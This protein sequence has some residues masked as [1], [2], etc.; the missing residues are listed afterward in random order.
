MNIY[1]IAQPQIR[2]TL[3]VIAWHHNTGSRK[4]LQEGLEKKEV[5]DICNIIYTILHLIIISNQ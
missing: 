2:Q 5:S 1:V 3:P 4:C